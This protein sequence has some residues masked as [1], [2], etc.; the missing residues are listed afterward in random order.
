MYNF[1]LLGKKF[2]LREEKMS[3]LYHQDYGYKID[4]I[5][6]WLINY[7][8]N[9]TNNIL[10]IGSN[11]GLYSIAY[12]IIFPKSKVYSFEPSPEIFEVLSSNL[13]LNKNNVQNIKPINI[14]ISKSKNTL[15]FGYPTASQ[16]S[17]YSNEKDLNSGLISTCFLRFSKIKFI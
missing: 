7:N 1:S 8:L 6:R 11:I 12:S 13:N 5:F 3:N 15:E 14:A 9:L 4:H 17:R 16:H 2:S 10:D